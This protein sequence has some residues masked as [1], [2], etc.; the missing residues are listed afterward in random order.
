RQGR[1]NCFLSSCLARS[2]VSRRPELRLRPARLIS[3]FSRDIAERNGLD[4]RRLLL[5]AERFREA[6]I[7]RAD[8]FVKTSGSRSSALLVRVTRADQRR[9]LPA[10][11]LAARRSAPLM[12]ARSRPEL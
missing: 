12:V 5:S 3:K 2:S 1:L 10:A 6:A 11:L 4:L 8:F 7:S 9:V